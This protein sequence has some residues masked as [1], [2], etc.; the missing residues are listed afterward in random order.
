VAQMI[1]SQSKA[2]GFKLCCSRLYH[3]DN[4]ATAFGL[5]KLEDMVG[6]SVTYPSVCR[7]VRCFAVSF[8]FPSSSKDARMLRLGTTSQINV[9]FVFFVQV[10][11]VHL[12][13]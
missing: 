5:P 10:H 7:C 2:T 11:L 1:D 13:V 8:N 9:L 4:Q 3:A 12:A 6:N